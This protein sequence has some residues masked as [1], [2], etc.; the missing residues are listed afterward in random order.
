MLF[1]VCVVWVPYIGCGLNFNLVTFCCV[2]GRGTPCTLLMKFCLLIKKKTF[3]FRDWFRPFCQRLIWAFTL[4]NTIKVGR[5][6]ERS[7][8]LFIFIAS[9]NKLLWLFRERNTDTERE[10]STS[11]IRRL[12]PYLAARFRQNQKVII[13]TAT[14]SSSSYAS[15]VIHHVA[16]FSSSASASASMDTVHMT[17]SC[18]RVWIYV[19]SLFFYDLNIWNM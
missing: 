11:L 7:Y 2:L 18:I 14:T 1:F 15:S 10:M 17:E 8:H 19:L 9:W 12:G 16:S 6:E 4:K 13:T 3:L 5:E